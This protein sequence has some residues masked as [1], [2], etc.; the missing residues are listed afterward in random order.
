MNN[1]TMKKAVSKNLYLD[2]RILGGAEAYVELCKKTRRAFCLSQLVEELL[3]R[4]LRKQRV[5]LPPE[6]AAK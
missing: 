4:E 6:F 2:P 5:K 1:L 3:V